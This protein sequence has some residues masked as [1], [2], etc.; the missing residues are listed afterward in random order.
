VD[1]IDRKWTAPFVEA[2]WSDIA[3]SRSA[4]AGA[5]RELLDALLVNPFAVD[6]M[7]DG[8][9]RPSICLPKSASGE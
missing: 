9:T 5:A 6:E 4:V 8:I 1:A 2:H 7:A 3:P